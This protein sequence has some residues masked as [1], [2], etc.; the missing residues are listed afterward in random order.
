MKPPPDCLIDRTKAGLVIAG[1]EQF[2]LRHKS[3]VSCRMKFA[4]IGS[5]P[6]SCFI[7][8]SAHRR[9]SSVSG[10]VTSLAPRRT[11]SSVC[12]TI[13][14]ARR[15]RFDARRLR[16]VFEDTGNRVDKGPFTVCAGTVA[17][18]ERMLGRDAGQ[19][20][21]KHPLHISYQFS[22][23]IQDTIEVRLPFRAIVGAWTDSCCLL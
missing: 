22:V 10:T 3:K 13:I 2:Q 6:V 4:R 9:P 7:L 23:S 21:S 15:E 18:E 5:P 8:L 17:E 11:A 19:R 1:D 12:V 14:S 20:I 16:I